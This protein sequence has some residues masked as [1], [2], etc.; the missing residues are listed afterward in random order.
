M[1]FP[2]P[3]GPVTNTNSPRSIVERET[4]QNRAI[5]PVRLEDVVED[6]HRSIGRRRVKALPLTQC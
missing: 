2:E 6:Q 1:L 3:L 5:R 4:A